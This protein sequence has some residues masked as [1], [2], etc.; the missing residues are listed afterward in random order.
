MLENRIRSIRMRMVAAAVDLVN[1]VAYGEGMAKNEALGREDWI[2]AGTEAL[3][4]GG[5]AAVRVEA[6]ARALGVTKGS[7]YW[8][9]ANRGAWVEAM[10][11]A[12]EQRQT[13]SVI[14]QVEQ[15]GGDAR[16]RLE[17]LARLASLDSDDDYRV[18]MAL[19]DE[20]R[21]NPEIAAFVERVDERRM[22]YLRQLFGDLGYGELETEARS[23]LAYSLLIG[24]Y[25]IAPSP[26]APDRRDVLRACRN[27]LFE[28]P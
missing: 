24:D 7:F 25:F 21:R 12:W 11:E 1:T 15:E 5:L 27:L 9:F 23:L 19:R 28:S 13:L 2:R 26:G 16:A 20:A 18:E 10:L 8:H 4:S 22:G 14:E 6:L 3:A 17:A